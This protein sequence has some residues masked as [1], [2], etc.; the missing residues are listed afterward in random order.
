M[1]LPYIESTC[2]YNTE[3]R[4]RRWLIQT[5]KISVFTLS[6][7]FSNWKLHW[8][9]S[10]YAWRR[11]HCP[12]ARQNSVVTS[13]TL[14]VNLKVQWQCSDTKVIWVYGIQRSL[15]WYTV[16]FALIRPHLWGIRFYALPLC[17]GVYNEEIWGIYWD[18]WLLWVS[19]TLPE[20]G[21]YLF[22]SWKGLRTR[23]TGKFVSKFISLFQLAVPSPRRVAPYA[24]E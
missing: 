1:G 3:F 10:E 5:R 17:L 19:I 15:N 23:F 12:R 9:P 4:E 20:Q 24:A 13:M 22:F 16:S 11:N 7:K 14:I 6:V 18:E 21:C 8:Y 2:D